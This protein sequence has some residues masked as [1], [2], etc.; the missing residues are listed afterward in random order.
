MKRAKN[1]GDSLKNRRLGSRLADERGAAVLVEVA[2]AA[3][4]LM[5]AILPIFAALTASL[6]S[7]ESSVAVTLATNLLQ[8]RAEVLK[9]AGY[10]LVAVDPG[11]PVRVLENY[12]GHPFDIL[13]EVSFVSTMTG[14]EGASLVKKVILTIYR[15]PYQEGDRSLARWEFLLYE[16]GI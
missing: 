5:L 4:I 2:V 15:H 8:D 12:E 13:E 7:L 3:L 6:L 10:Y 9:A 14:S 11:N 16:G 1:S